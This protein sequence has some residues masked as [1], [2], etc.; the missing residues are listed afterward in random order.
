M[1][2]KVTR[3]TFTDKSTIGDLSIDGA[4]LCHTLEDKVREP[5]VKVPGKTAIP[6]GRYQIVIDM[7][8]R[9][10]KFMPHILN[11][12]MFEGVRV[13]KGNTF[14][15]TEGCLIVG[16]VPGTDFVGN[17]KEAYDKFYAKLEEGLKA[18]P[19]FITIG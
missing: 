10:K 15:D 9:F 16:M 13:H 7:S 1:E 5:G 17:S 6:P 2:I 14:M 18:G 3:K 12:P 4:F 8:A 19:V 11:V